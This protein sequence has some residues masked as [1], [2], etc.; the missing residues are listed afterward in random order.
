MTLKLQSHKLAFQSIYLSNVS[1][2]FTKFSNPSIRPSTQ[3]ILST[4][5]LQQRWTNLQKQS[6][7]FQRPLKILFE[8]LICDVF[9]VLNHVWIILFGAPLNAF[10]LPQ[11]I[12]KQVDGLK[13]LEKRF[14]IS[15]SGITEQ[16]AI[17][18]V[19]WISSFLDWMK[20]V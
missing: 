20:K 4:Y 11:K 3:S 18:R 13:F 6:C 2:T 8:H 14:L 1:I 17:N 9:S 15:P 16:I 19:P 7:L 12:T 5:S 10:R